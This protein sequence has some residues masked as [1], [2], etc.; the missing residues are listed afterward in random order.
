MR[1]VTKVLLV[2]AVVALAVG[3]I[4]FASYK[5]GGPS[6]PPTPAPVAQKPAADRPGYNDPLETY[7]RWR[8]RLA[9]PGPTPPTPGQ[10]PDTRRTR[11]SNVTS[12][13]EHEGTVAARTSTTPVAGADPPG[14]TLRPSSV[15]GQVV[16][17]PIR[18]GAVG[19]N[20]YTVVSG[21]TLYGIAMKQYGDP[22]FVQQIQAANPGI[23]SRMLKIGEKIVLPDKSVAAKPSTPS[24]ATPGASAPASPATPQG[25]VYVVQK[26]DTLIGIARR[27]YGDAAAYRKVYEANKDILASPNATLYVGQR[28]RLP[29]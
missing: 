16:T 9:S 14:P 7:E 6:A 2:L 24:P 1:P 22:R 10:T 28:L 21:D 5:W 25:K 17:G 15:D 13:S 29:E 8:Q 20:S 26:N 12:S 27:F 4:W 23:E 11:P 3:V 19:G 18:T